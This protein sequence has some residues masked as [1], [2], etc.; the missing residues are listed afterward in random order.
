MFLWGRVSRRAATPTN[1]M[2]CSDWLDPWGTTQEHKPGIWTKQQ[3]ENCLV[4]NRNFFC[5]ARSGSFFM[6]TPGLQSGC[7]QISLQLNKPVYLPTVY[8]QCP[9][10]ISSFMYKETWN[11]RKKKQSNKSSTTRLHLGG[12][13]SISL[14]SDFPCWDDLPQLFW[15]SLG[16]MS[17]SDGPAL[18]TPHG[19]L[20]PDS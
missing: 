15:Q 10:R 18:G 4:I 17:F 7:L 8:G 12:R 5:T 9:R 1:P 6:M 14:R 19:L 20:K 13:C 2:G 3:F 16:I 11:Y